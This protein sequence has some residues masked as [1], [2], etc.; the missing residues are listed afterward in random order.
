MK[1]K[2]FKESPETD[3]TTIFVLVM[4][5]HIFYGVLPLFTIQHDAIGFSKS[6]KRVYTKFNRTVHNRLIC[7]LFTFTY[8][9]ITR[10][11]G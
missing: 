9:L 6:I 3:N 2:H 10:P 5:Q 1:N 4:S 7:S 8:I 11:V